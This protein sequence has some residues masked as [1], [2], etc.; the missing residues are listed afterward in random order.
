MACCPQWCV[1]DANGTQYTA[2]LSNGTVSYINQLDPTD[3]TPTQPV[4]VCGEVAFQAVD[5]E[6]G[7]RAFDPASDCVPLAAFQRI[8][9]HHGHQLDANACDGN[10]LILHRTMGIGPDTQLPGD[11]LGVLHADSDDAAITAVTTH[12]RFTV[13][14]STNSSATGLNSAAIAS[15]LASTASGAQSAVIASQGSTASGRWALAT[16]LLTNATGDRSFASGSQTTASGIAS[17]VG[18]FSSVASGTGAVAFGTSN[19]SLAN[20][21]FIAGGEGNVIN[22]T[23]QS[24]FIAGQ[25]NVVNDRLGSALGL[26]LI[27]DVY[28]GV[29]VGRYNDPVNAGGP[30]NAVDFFDYIFVVGTGNTDADR[31]NGFAVRQDHTF[32][33]EEWKTSVGPYPDNAAAIASL[34]GSLTAPL[35]PGDLR[36]V[37]V[38]G[39]PTYFKYDGAGF[40]FAF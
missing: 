14:S 32:H 1:K 31:F 17:F 40:V 16:N 18:G 33:F 19:Q 37:L 23:G 2:V 15:N 36:M 9:D 29:V 5:A 6:S 21:G 38:A 10:P 30:V 12:H 8:E 13:I 39:V 24:S 7:V 28:D 34:N 4:E 26:G 27:Q 3:T 25:D 11:E 22:A 20:I 35:S